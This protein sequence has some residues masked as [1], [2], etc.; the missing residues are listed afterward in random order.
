MQKQI[1]NKHIYNITQDKHFKANKRTL[2]TNVV[3]MCNQ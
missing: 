1:K 2:I 3:L